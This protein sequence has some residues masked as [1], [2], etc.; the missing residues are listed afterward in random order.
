MALKADKAYDMKRCVNSKI[1]QTCICICIGVDLA[2]PK[3]VATREKE[4]E[5]QFK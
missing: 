3:R 5:R 4:L 1:L 2:E